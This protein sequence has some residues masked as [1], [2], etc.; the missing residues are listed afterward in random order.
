MLPA[1]CSADKTAASRV[2]RESRRLMN[3]IYIRQR[4]CTAWRLAEAWPIDLLA[5]RQTKGACTPALTGFN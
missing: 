1:T 5:S 4:P 2:A 3:P